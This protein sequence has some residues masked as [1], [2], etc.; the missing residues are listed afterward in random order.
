MTASQPDV[1]FAQ[2][3]PKPNILFILT[4]DMRASDLDHM[5][6]T[7]SLLVNKGVKFTK[8]WV[9]R[10]LCCPSRASTLRG[11]YTHNHD[12]WVNVEPVGG[13]PRF[14]ELGHEGSTIATWLNAA[15]YDIIL[16]GKYLNR[17]GLDRYGIN[18]PTTHVPPGWEASRYL[19]CPGP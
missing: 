6:N 15:G 11:Q 5:P 16:I 18:T 3:A 17:Y 2:T 19:G 1:G 9:T 12:V 4:D 7:K 8:A 14:R 13:F 10:S